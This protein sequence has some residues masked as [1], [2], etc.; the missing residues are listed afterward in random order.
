MQVSRFDPWKDPVGVI[1]AFKKARREVDATLV[2]LGDFASDDPEGTEIYESIK[3]QQE[4]RIL[5]LPCGDD[6]A[7]VNT[8][9]RRAAVVMQK[10]IREGFGLTVTEAMWKETPVIGG[11]AG[12]ITKQHYQAD[13]GRGERLFGLVSG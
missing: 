11:R 9:Q 5:I 1:E 12:G 13:C 8:L 2:L 10:S 6:T 4:E 3:S 7:L